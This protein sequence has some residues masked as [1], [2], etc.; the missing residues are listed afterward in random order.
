M[1]R[2]QNEFGFVPGVTGNRSNKQQ[3]IF[4]GVY[5]PWRHGF[6]VRTQLRWDVFLICVS[7]FYMWVSPLIILFLFYLVSNDKNIGTVTNQLSQQP[8]A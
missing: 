8:M 3:F 1:Q 7:Y 4:Y 2:N 5:R 6:I